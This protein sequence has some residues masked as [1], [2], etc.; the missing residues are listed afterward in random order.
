MKLRRRWRVALLILLAALL[1][2]AAL[3][4]RWVGPLPNV[5]LLDA[6]VAPPSTLILDRHG[7][8]LY[9]VADPQRGKNTPLPL[10]RVPLACRQAT[11]A[12][13]DAAF[14]SH[15]GVDL[16]AIARAFWQNLRAG[17]TVSGASTLT[18]QLARNLLLSE[19]ERDQRTLRRKVREAVLALK[20]ELR[21]GKDDLL[22]LYLNQTYY[23]HYAVGLEAAAQAYFGK[24]AAELDLA[25]C[26]LLA[27]LPQ[28]PQGY[29]PLE[30]PEAARTRQATVLGLMVRHGYLSIDD[31][32]RAAREPLRFA[33]TPFP[34]LAPHFVMYVQGL[35][36]EELGRERLA[37]GG[38]RV[39]T[40]LDADWQATAE[41]IVRYRLRQLKDDP[42]AP[43]DRRVENAALV[44]LD[45][46]TGEILAMVGSPNYFDL[47]TSGAVN[48][49]LALR[50]PGSSIKPITYAAAFDPERAARHGYA[51]Y[52]PATMVTDVRTVFPT[53]EGT[54]YV[55]Q[56]YDLEYHGPVLLRQALAA[57]LNIPAV[58]VLQYVGLEDFVEQARRLG[59]RTFDDPARYGL[60]LTLGGGEVRLLDL[61]AAYAAF[62][63][64]GRQVVP[65]AL[66]RVED[67]QGHVVRS[68][69]PRLGPQAVSPQVAYLITDILSDNAARASAF[70]EMSPLHLGFPAAA[71]TGTTTD[72]RD[73]WTLGYTPDLAVGVWV[74]NAD[75]APMLDVSGI[76]G[77]APIWRDFMLAVTREGRAR[78]FPRPPGLVEVEVCADTGLL[79]NDY[80]P[81]RTEL[82]IAGTEPTARDE[83]Y[84][85]GYIDAATAAPAT[86][87]TPP[88]R[89]VRRIARV[90]PAE[91]HEWARQH[92]ILLAEDAGVQTSAGEGGGIKS[93]ETSV[94]LLL[95][96]PDPNAIF[97]LSPA[98]PAET[99]RL[100]IAAR[101]GDGIT[102]ARLTLLAD[103][104]P[105]A[106]FGAPPYR[107]WWPLQVGQHEFR[108]VGIDK[109]GREIASAPV[110]ITVER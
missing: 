64:G 1:G 42:E 100:E 47:R 92:G 34:I 49:A 46:A 66:L 3:F 81:R 93:G 94:P 108:A 48:G 82:F 104:I 32:E 98:I 8:L 37:Q 7:R 105:L 77:A 88:E 68:W 85:L 73:N 53:R 79:P 110:R 96:S 61:T 87:E 15:P 22:A 45:P 23:G 90:L 4:A 55:P 109:D 30:N 2:G 107:A 25:E 44:A 28:W 72:W 29:N 36:E 70:G 95:A 63:N 39:Y 56:N 51:P 12:T 38:L 75:N 17:R 5:S 74:G 97:R 26:A 35:L 31:A 20:L 59:I 41:N 76:A 52:T 83:S 103:G 102:L 57:S 33:S 67:A 54:P 11:I 106:E 99:Q 80:C 18:Q 27:G 69:E 50:Q 40:T 6:R 89:R 58:K 24:S 91:L 84:R 10:E 19:E 65:I 9:E 101:P 78:A 86:D 16:W 21:Y 71:K 14:Y 62:A 43:P 60:A 13:E